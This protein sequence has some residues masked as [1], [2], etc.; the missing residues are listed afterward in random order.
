[1]INV[2]KKSLTVNHNSIEAD[3]LR[4]L[5]KNIGKISVF[6]NK[7]SAKNV[8]KKF[9]RNLMIGA[10]FGATTVSKNPKSAKST[11]PDVIKF[12]QTGEVL[13]LGK[14]ILIF[15]KRNVYKTLF[16]CSIGTNYF[17]DERLVEKTND[18]NGF[19]NSIN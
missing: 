17:V 19:N 16:F 11:I 15:G 13:K 7:Y 1:M 14:F 2:F 8:L 3:G 9:G 12:H 18:I 5:M 10:N 6:S 4:N